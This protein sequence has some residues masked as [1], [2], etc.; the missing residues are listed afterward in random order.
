[1]VGPFRRTGAFAEALAA[2]P[3][4]MKMRLT[5]KRFVGPPKLAP[6]QQQRSRSRPSPFLLKGG[7]LA[8]RRK[9]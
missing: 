9:Q 8:R 7:A 4:N 2:C 6:Q 3:L 5:L 1:M